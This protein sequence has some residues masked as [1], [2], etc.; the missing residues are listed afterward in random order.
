MAFEHRWTCPHCGREL[1]SP[2]SPEAE[3]HAEWR[4]GSMGRSWCRACDEYVVATE[5]VVE[6]V[7]A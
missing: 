6:R 1:R 3:A 2:Y 5:T 7:P 4:L